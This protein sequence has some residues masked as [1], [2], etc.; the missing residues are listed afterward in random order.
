MARRININ[1]PNPDKLIQIHTTGQWEQVITGM[2]AAGHEVLKGYEA[3]V[4]EYG[5]LVIKLVRDAIRKGSPPGGGRWEP[6][7][8][9]YQRKTRKH[10][11]YDLTGQYYA[12]VGVY[13]TRKRTWVGMPL[14]TRYRSKESNLTLNQIAKILE[15]GRA[16]GAGSNYIADDGDGEG[17][18]MDAATSFMPARPLWRPA[19]KVSGGQAGIRAILLKNIRRSLA[20]AFGISNNQVRITGRSTYG[21]KKL[22]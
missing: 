19:F 11:P 5:E 12:S 17:D 15:F 4:R 20:K 8:E 16:G 2:E 21:D 13:Q 10:T 9:N 18:A 22:R 3:G 1:L 7:S 14:N 6:L